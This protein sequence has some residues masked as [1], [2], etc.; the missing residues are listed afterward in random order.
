MAKVRLL[1]LLQPARSFLLL[2]QPQ[3]TSLL[4]TKTFGTRYRMTA[5]TRQG[6][7]P[8]LLLA[9]LIVDVIVL[10]FT[11]YFPQVLGRPLNTW[12]DRFG[13]LAVLSDVT[14]IAIGFWLARWLF[15]LL[16]GGSLWTFLGLLVT[17]QAVHDILFYVG[18]ILPIPRGHNAMIDV[19]KDYAA[20]GGA[21][22]LFGDAGLMLA[23]A[24]VFLGLERLSEPLVW[25]AGLLTLYTLPYILLTKPQ[26]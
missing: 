26:Y 24:A 15:G 16:G 8:Q 25:G 17:V 18:V 11:R 20:S 19:F 13:L 12:Y 21:K 2:V 5:L 1:L 22:I 9:I 7:W 4:D 23:S 3:R 14:I 6:S 10:F